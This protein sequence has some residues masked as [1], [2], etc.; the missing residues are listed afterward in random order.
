MKPYPVN[1]KWART[2]LYV[3]RIENGFTMREVEKRT[4]VSPR[5][6]S[7]YERAFWEPKVGVAIKLAKF[8]GVTVEE[9]FS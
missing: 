3:K 4:G 7:E 6:L 1:P 2:R 5:R 9:L 8:F